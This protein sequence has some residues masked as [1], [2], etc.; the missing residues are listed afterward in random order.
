V[1]ARYDPRSLRPHTHA[2]QAAITPTRMASYLA[3]AKN[4]M[5][6]AQ[7]LYVWDRD[8]STALLA[9]VA[10]LEVALRN[11]LNKQLVLAFGPDW[12]RQDIGLDDRTRNALALAWKKLPHGKR[13]LDD[14][15]SRLMFGF[16]RDLLSAG[17]YLGRE[18]QRF[19]C[20]YEKLWRSALHLAFPGG[21]AIATA[22]GG[23][24][25]RTWTLEIVSLVHATRNRAAHHEPFITG[26]PLPGQHSRVTVEHA[27]AASLKLAGL[28][29]RDLAIALASLS[30]V[31][32]VLSVRP[33]PSG[34]SSATADLD[35]ESNSRH[36]E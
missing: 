14:L 13:T 2:L 27:Y 33:V 25:T 24:F 26:F 19:Q 35:P 17:G 30:S 16:W 7:A 11:A 32:S 5:E 23:R 6:L 1:S 9:D 20:D 8:V 10:L 36:I 22:E 31:P 12:Y 15:V 28:L 4:D 29:D 34:A 3:T 21:K 18:P